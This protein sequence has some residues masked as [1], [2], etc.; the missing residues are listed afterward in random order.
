MRWFCDLAGLSAR[1]PRH[2][3]ERRLARHL[4][5]ARR[6]AARPAAGELPL[7]H[8]L[9]LRPGAPLAPEGGDAGRL[10]GRRTC[11]RSRRTTRSA[12][13]C[14]ALARGDR[15]GPRGGQDALPRRRQRRHDEHRRGRRSRRRSPSSPRRERL[16]F[17][18][19]GAYGGFFLLTAE[20]RR[21]MAGIERADSI[22]L[23]PHKGLFLPYGTGALLVRDGEAL[24][25]AH[26][27]SA[28]YLPSM[29]EDPDLVDFNLLS[30]ELSRDF[31]GLRVWLPLKMHGI[32]PFR[33][34][35][36]EKLALA[37]WATEELRAD[38]GHRDPR[39]AAALDRGVPPAPRRARRGRA[40]PAQPRICSTAS[41][42]R[43][44]VY[45]TGTL[46]A[47][48]LRDPHLRAL[49]PH[50]PRPD[51]AGPRGHPRRGRRDDPEVRPRGMHM[52]RTDQARHSLLR[53]RRDRHPRRHDRARR[54]G[55]EVRQAAAPDRRLRRP[56][57][58]DPVR[59]E[60]GAREPAGASS[61]ARRS[62]SSTSSRAR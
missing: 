47:R 38:P 48:P 19:D 44:R 25:R 37:R 52:T 39:R 27:L 6:R 55:P 20:G 57:A 1:G 22:V 30:P 8:A 29:Q 36:E 7:G 15:R 4:L 5:G 46:L 56:H 61:G 31:R 32:G 10:P 28:D 49:L 50:A 42:R 23:D 16:W 13:A 2:P 60:A 18:V 58:D 40:R 41:T 51:G 33:T 14:D 59:D 53:P 35:L 3:D 9:R 54:G 24:K 17:H 26:A 11:A 62:S 12:F 45:L 21:R 43:K 34:N